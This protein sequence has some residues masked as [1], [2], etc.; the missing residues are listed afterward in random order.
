LRLDKTSVSDSSKSDLGRIL[1]NVQSLKTPSSQ[2]L[3]PAHTGKSQ[4]NVSRSVLSLINSAALPADKLSASIVT[5][6]RF[7]SL[8]LKPELMAAIRRQAFTQSSGETTQEEPLKQTAAENKTQVLLNAK[9]RDALSMAAAAAESKGVE[10][11][12]KGLEA[13]AEAADPELYGRQKERQNHKQKNKNQNE[14]KDEN[15]ALKPSNINAAN[16]EKTALEYLEKDPLLNTLNKLP[17][18]NGQRWIVIPLD[19]SQDGKEY[20]VSLK[21]LL[22]AEIVTNR[23]V[24][25]TLDIAETGAPQSRVSFVLE[26]A[27]N[28]LKRLSVYSQ[29]DIPAKEQKSLKSEL[30]KLLEI[31]LNNVSVQT[32][33]DL[34]LCAV[35]DG[36]FLTSIDEVV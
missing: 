10:L 21:I 7:F 1:R 33:P 35:C 20:R 14:Q 36:R 28:K 31:P 16:L 23:S 6:A 32:C 8:P 12:P 5:F 22:E 30:S 34:I 25:M 26:A 3:P 2:S 4:I 13:Y 9:Y 18:K 19:F 27:N 17:G 11:N 15:A 24:L 29:A